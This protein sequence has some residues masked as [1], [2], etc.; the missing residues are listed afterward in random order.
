MLIV[1]WT[2]PQSFLMSGLLVEIYG[3]RGRIVWL[4]YLVLFANGSLFSFCL[5]GC[6]REYLYEESIEILGDLVIPHYQFPHMLLP[7]LL[8]SN[9]HMSDSYFFELKL[10]S[11]PNGYYLLWCG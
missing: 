9:C 5:F 2:L 1:C 8:P 10:H 7:V 3:G 6:H 11:W 4:G